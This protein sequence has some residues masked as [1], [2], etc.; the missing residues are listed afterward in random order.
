M[1]EERDTEVTEDMILLDEITEKELKY[2]D[3]LKE[4]NYGKHSTKEQEYG[5]NIF[6]TCL[7]LITILIGFSALMLLA[8]GYWKIVGFIALNVLVAAIVWFLGKVSNGFAINVKIK[9]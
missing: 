4:L 5:L 8:F 6:Q 2:Y 1:K 7:I 9:E 3:R